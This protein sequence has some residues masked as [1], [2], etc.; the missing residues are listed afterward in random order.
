MFNLIFFFL[1][2]KIYLKSLWS[3]TFKKNQFGEYTGQCSYF[4]FSKEHIF[5]HTFSN[6]NFMFYIPLLWTIRP[7]FDFKNEFSGKNFQKMT[8]ITSHLIK[9]CKYAWICAQK[10]K[11]AWVRE[12]F[13][14]LI[15]F[16]TME[17]NIS[18]K[19]NP[20]WHPSTATQ[21]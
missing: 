6:W 20:K 1:N 14:H 2:L 9:K 21:R 15:E 12:H 7:C 17:I 4:S 11:C 3:E 8:T 18:A 19:I 5:L 13:L 16:L 10:P